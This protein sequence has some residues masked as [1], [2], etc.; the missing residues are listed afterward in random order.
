LQRIVEELMTT[1][2]VDTQRTERRSQ[3]PW[4]I[5]ATIVGFVL[6]GLIVHNA[7]YGAVS[8]RIRNPNVANLLT[9]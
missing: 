7:R 9:C 6:L 1:E 5:A 4:L 8:P 2:Q 3:K